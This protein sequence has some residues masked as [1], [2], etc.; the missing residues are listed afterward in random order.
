MTAL[1]EILLNNLPHDR[2]IEAWAYG[3]AKE[4][5][6]CEWSVHDEAA[7]THHSLG[8]LLLPRHRHHPYTGVGGEAGGTRTQPCA[9]TRR[10]L[11]GTRSFQGERTMNHLENVASRLNRPFFAGF[12]VGLL[13]ALVAIL[14][15]GHS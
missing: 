7:T 13:T 15:V 14:V 11:P 3:E 4:C 5:E 9:G 1:R 12:V 10:P 2:L 6:G 8:L